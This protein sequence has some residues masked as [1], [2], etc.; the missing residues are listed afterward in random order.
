MW[1]QPIDE[2]VLCYPCRMLE[3]LSS[4]DGLLEEETSQSRASMTGSISMFGAIGGKIQ[5]D[6]RRHAMI[7]HDI[8]FIHCHSQEYNQS[9]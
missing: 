2:V 4:A 5:L 1:V 9:E 7:L 3:Q 8:F 6:D